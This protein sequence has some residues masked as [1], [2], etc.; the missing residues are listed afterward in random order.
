MH[1]VDGRPGNSCY[2]A[3][4]DSGRL[5]HPRPLQDQDSGQAGNKGRDTG[6]V[7]QDDSRQGKARQ[8]CCQS[9]PGC[10]FEE[11]HLS[12]VSVQLFINQVCFSSLTVGF[13]AE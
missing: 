8:D 7:R 9:I 5:H 11:E 6:D 10:C 1:K 12:V 2:R 3:G 4:E 13:S